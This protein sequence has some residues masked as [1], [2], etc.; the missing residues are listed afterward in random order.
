MHR[1]ISSLLR[2]SRQVAFSIL[3]LGFG[4]FFSVAHGGAQVPEVAPGA[5]DP[6]LRSAL[7]GNRPRWAAAQNDRGAVASDL[8]LSHVTL[9]LKRSPQRQRAFEQFLAELQNPA[10]ARYHRWLTPRQVGERFGVSAGDLAAITNWLET[11]GMR[12]ESVSNSRMMIDFSGAASVVGAAFGTEIH[13][14][15][16]GSDLLLAPRDEPQ[17]P[18][19]LS[20]VIGS[21]S[22]LYTVPDHPYSHARPVMVAASDSSIL[23]AATFCNNGNCSHYIFPNDFSAIYDLNSVYNQGITGS[24]QTIAVIGRAKVYNTDI[25]NFESLAGLAKKDPVVIV[26]PGGIDPGPPATTG[27]APGDQLEATLDVE[28]ST[29]VAPGATIDLVVSANSSTVSG[30]RVAAQYVVDTT[31]VVAHIMNISFGACEANRTAADVQFWDSLFSQAAAAGISVYVASGDSGA[32]GCDPYNQTP[33]ATQG[34]ASPNY[35]CASSYGTCVG[36]TEFADASNPGGYWSPG[37]GTGYESALGY[38]P[39]GGWNEPMASGG[40]FVASASGGGMSTYINQPAWQTGSGVGAGPGRYSPDLAFSSSGHDGYFGCMAASG[41]GNTSCVVSNGSFGFVYFFGT[42][43]AAPDMAG[44]T[45]LLN[46]KLGG[47]Q[48]SL[49]SSLYQL[50]A[51]TSNG[52]FHDVTVSS[53]AVSG[54][55]VSTPS[56]CN[57]ST[58]SSTSLTGGLAGFLVGTGYDEVTGLGSLDVANFL[59]NFTPQDFSWAGSGSHTVKAGQASLAYSFT[60]A[61]SGAATFNSTVTFSCSFSPADPTLTSS[62]CAFTPSSITA[63]LGATSVAVTITSKGPNPGNG[64]AALPSV[65]KRFP[66]LAF[67]F[68]IAGVV[69]VGVAGGR[70]S[71]SWRVAGVCLSLVV[72]GWLVACGGGGSNPPPIS[73][74]LGPGNPASLFPNDAAAGWPTQTATFHATV[75]NDPA[76]KGVTWSVVGSPAKG[77]IDATGVYTAP[78]VAAGLPSSVT[79][80]ATSVSDPTKSA[81]AQETLTPATLPGTYTVTVTATE[82]TVSHSAPVTLLVQ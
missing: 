50:A 59:N 75:S 43:A 73:V 62:S 10:S 16:V 63:G 6:A 82:G 78:S 48:G 42:S 58:P 49:N 74:N 69:M 70:L 53:S 11:Q 38:I 81:S 45:A 33:P 15:Q 46:Q 7:H 65:Q 9:V 29:S 14:Y 67:S 68:P 39:E 64:T 13:S 35:I 32:A 20:G 2:I 57:N 80:T 25:E 44:I 12:V 28:R 17:I 60:A 5:V 24:G 30:L 27:T 47:P 72:L 76:N 8:R 56:M 66:W 51:S 41:F 55:T 79:I 54:C 19:A 18:A 26:P 40:Q 34:P 52:V 21:V 3:G 31:P 37:N 71:R 61:P 77:T 22:G 1:S 36:G 4:L 23:P